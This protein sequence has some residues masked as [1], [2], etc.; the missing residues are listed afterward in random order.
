MTSFLAEIERE[1][2]CCV[3]SFHVTRRSRL[4]AFFHFEKDYL[5]QQ[6][7]ARISLDF[8]GMDEWMAFVP[9]G[10]DCFVFGVFFRNKEK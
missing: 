5:N 9:K 8:R 4:W 2:M 1:P 10:L 6:R 3:V 7:V